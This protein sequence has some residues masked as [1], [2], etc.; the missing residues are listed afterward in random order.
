MNI[1]LSVF[2]PENWVSRV[3]SGSSIR[4]H[5]AHLH[6]KAESGAY[7]ISPEFRGSVYLSAYL[8]VQ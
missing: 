7:G 4:R 6:T 3:G 5:P 2:A 1:S 8:I